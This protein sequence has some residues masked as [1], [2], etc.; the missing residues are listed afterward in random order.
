MEENVTAPD[1]Q[2][3]STQPDSAPDPS[4]SAPYPTLPITPDPTLHQIIERHDK[5]DLTKEY[6]DR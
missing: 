2:P 3:T 4:A 6:R 5:P 1:N